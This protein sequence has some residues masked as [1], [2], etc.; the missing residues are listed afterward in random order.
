M[1]TARKTPPAKGSPAVGNLRDARKAQAAMRL[2][3]AP[4]PSPSPSRT[5][6]RGRMGAGRQAGH[7]ETRAAR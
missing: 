2:T 7:R 4:T 6:A 1:A 5:S 3:A